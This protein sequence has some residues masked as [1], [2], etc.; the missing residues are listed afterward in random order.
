MRRIL[1]AL[2]LLLLSSGAF[3]ATLIATI[4][5]AN[6]Q[7]VAAFNKGDAAGIAALYT[8]TATALPPGGDI[9]K[10]RAAIQAMWQGALGTGL[11][12]VSLTA[13]DVEPMGNHA[14]EIGRFSFDAPGANGAVT[15]VE[16]KY[17]VVWKRVDKAWKLDIDIWNT[18]K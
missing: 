15:K 6:D 5:K 3:A 9:T 18:N 2:P 4:Q 17:V 10:G 11:K 1:L 16:G 13:L 14:R 12:N 7:F 8:E